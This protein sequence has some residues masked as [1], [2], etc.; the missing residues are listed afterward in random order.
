MKFGLGQ[1]DFAGIGNF[2]FSEITH[3]EAGSALSETTTINNDSHTHIHVYKYIFF[4]HFKWN[5]SRLQLYRRE[6]LTRVKTRLF[7]RM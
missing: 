3:Q 4:F 2:T 7:R 5:L 6:A 1:I